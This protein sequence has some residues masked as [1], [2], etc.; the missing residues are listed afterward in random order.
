M[1]ARAEPEPVGEGRYRGTRMDPVLRDTLARYLP[2]DLFRQVVADVASPPTGDWV[3]R[4]RAF[5]L[6]EPVRSA[7]VFLR[8]SLEKRELGQGRELAL[9]DFEGLLLEAID[10]VVDQYGLGESRTIDELVQHLAPFV[11]QLDVAHGRAPD[12]GWARQVAEEALEVLLN[13]RERQDDI[14]EAPH[15]AFVHHHLVPGA[16]PRVAR[17]PFLLLETAREGDR[18]VVRARQEAVL[19]TVRMLDFDLEEM[20]EVLETLLERQMDR[21][22]F[23]GAVHTAQQGRQVA[24][25]YAAQIRA[26][27]DEARRRPLT[28]GYAR[29]LRPILD[30]ARTHLEERTRRERELRE[31]VDDLRWRSASDVLDAL[32]RIER[33]LEACGRVYAA[34]LRAINEAPREHALGRARAIAGRVAPGRWPDPLD[35]VLLP[36]LRLPAAAVEA[37]GPVILRRL[38]PPV[39]PRLFDLAALVDRVL[40]AQPVERDLPPPEEEQ[41]VR[42]LPRPR[43][44][45]DEAE[46][47]IRALALRAGAGGVW[48]S[49]LLAQAGDDEALAAAVAFVAHR[50]RRLADE[51][52]NTPPV[53]SVVE[54][55]PRVRVGA[56]VADDLRV[57]AGVSAAYPRPSVPAE[58]E[59]SHAR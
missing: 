18:I 44:P 4:S 56:I 50:A 32:A 31:T 8:R 17:F 38:S 42:E 26:S 51:P 43:L 16:A 22:N 59:V 39:R 28:S 29:H 11:E 45:I 21:G 41:V 20:G 19:F 14:V 30:R 2:A 54:V 5:A 36:A 13:R 52:G 23:A 48:L 55:G 9:W 37:A 6:F 49:S 58:V 27:L 46:A 12:A 1:N 34:L 7:A 24:S 25:G 47:L 53:L 40:G 10:H 3:A 15:R 33:E 57:T 35:G